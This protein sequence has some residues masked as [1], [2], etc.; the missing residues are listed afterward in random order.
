MAR[1]KADNGKSTVNGNY[2]L[3]SGGNGKLVVAVTHRNPGQKEAL[4][5]ISGSKVT[6]ITGVPGT[7]KTHIAVGWGLQQMIMKD[8]FDQIIFTRPVVE[9]GESLGYLPGDADAKLAPY[10]MPM[11]DVLSDYLT[12]DQIT[13]LVAEKKIVT[14]PLAYMR[15]VTFKNA[16]VVCDEMQNSTMEQMHLLLTRIGQ[17]SK[18]VVTG[19]TEQSDL[20][21]HRRR[22]DPDFENGLADAIDRLEGT[23]GVGF[24]ELDYSSCVREEIISLIDSRYRSTP[25]ELPTWDK[26]VNLEEDDDEDRFIDFE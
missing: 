8:A 10:M 26:P 13:K 4:R 11:Y 24:V 18:V 12:N 23:K 21:Y 5:T 7:G 3:S 19:D 15:G 16:Y 14:L 9:A 6:F 1:K 17:G 22:R 20:C 25:P 2:T